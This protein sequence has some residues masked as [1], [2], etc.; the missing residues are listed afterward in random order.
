M[1]LS[2]TILGVGIMAAGL[3]VPSHEIV[4]LVIALFGVLV[5]AMGK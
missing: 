3:V 2:L 1:G 5:S 4:G